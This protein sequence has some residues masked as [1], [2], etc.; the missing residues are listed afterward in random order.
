MIISVHT[1][2]SAVF[3]Q[4]ENFRNL[5][6]KSCFPL[7]CEVKRKKSIQERILVLRNCCFKLPFEYQNIGLLGPF[8]DSCQ[9][10]TVELPEYPITTC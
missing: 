10:L 2:T 5:S 3:S 4:R 8:S 6:A 1:W 7:K 9:V